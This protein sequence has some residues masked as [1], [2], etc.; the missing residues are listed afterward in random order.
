LLELPPFFTLHCFET[1]GSSNDEARRLAEAGAPEG[2]LIWA[3]EQTA[4]R[5]R[6]GRSW[7]SPPGNLYLSLLLRPGVDYAAAPQ[8]GFVCALAMGE[9]VASLLPEGT[10]R[11]RY[12][13][14]NDLLVDGAKIG[15]ILLEAGPVMPRA[16]SAG[17][18]PGPCFVIAGIGVNIA[19]APADTPYPATALTE[20]GAVA[21]TPETLLAHFAQRFAAG[22][23][24]WRGEG[25][26][27]V[28]EAW[29]AAGHRVG[30]SLMVRIGGGQEVRGR[31]LDLD[32]D[33]ALLL[34]LESGERR[35]I[36]VG[37]VQMM[38]A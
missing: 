30:D 3:G 25:F 11:I 29:L 27:H 31:F 37:D 6:R 14:P 15:G 4:G 22:Y 23:P 20:A 36:G 8:L 13:W 28:R 7:A 38:A 5:G 21:G 26:A 35:R 16:T 33:G 24:A 12:K 9:A 1:I 34:E 17:V 32:A 2:T 18:D 10:G 19:S